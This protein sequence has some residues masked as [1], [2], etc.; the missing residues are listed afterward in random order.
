M[1]CFKSSACLSTGVVMYCQISRG[2]LSTCCAQ[3]AVDM[4][5]TCCA[6][7]AIANQVHQCQMCQGIFSLPQMHARLGLLQGYRRAEA[8][9]PWARMTN[10]SFLDDSVSIDDVCLGR[11]WARSGP[12]QCPS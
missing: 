3:I 12:R 6:Q 9:Q 5:L 1:R 8:G 11:C 2:L 7:L 4:L 10:T